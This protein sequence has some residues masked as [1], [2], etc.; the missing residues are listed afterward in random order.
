MTL[1]SEYRYMFRRTVTGPCQPK[2]GSCD[3]G[4]LSGSENTARKR[5]LP[6]RFAEA[7]AA[8]ARQQSVRWV[9]FGKDGVREIGETIASNLGEFRKSH[10]E[11]RHRT[12]DQ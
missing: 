12:A 11:D 9:L 7:A 6:E 1:P 2:A 10:W 3:A 8:V 5:W 4:A